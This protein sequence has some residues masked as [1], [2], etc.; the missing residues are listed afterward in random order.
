MS[1][2]RPSRAATVVA[3]Q[4]RVFFLCLKFALTR[5]D[6]SPA[7]RLCWQGSVC[8]SPTL[9]RHFVARGGSTPQSRRKKKIGAVNNVA[10]KQRRRE[11]M[12]QV[13][14][15]CNSPAV[16]ARA[17]ASVFAKKKKAEH[18]QYMMDRPKRSSEAATMEA[19]TPGEV[20]GGRMSGF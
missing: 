4:V 9:S 2:R 15:L 11:V 3:I 13:R 10:R 20:S 6:G 8:S 19:A 17:R 7:A 5:H 18:Q 1:K 12:L 14:V 16:R